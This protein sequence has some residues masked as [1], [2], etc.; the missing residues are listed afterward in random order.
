GAWQITGEAIKFDTNGALADGQHRLSAVVES[1]ASVDMLVVRG[2]APEAQTVMDSGAKRTASDA[3]TLVGQKHPAV[4]A[5]AA[6]FALREPGA[7]YVA[8]DDAVRNPTNT[9]IADFIA[10]NP[11]LHQAAEIA[12]HYYPSFDAPPSVLAV[13][14]MRF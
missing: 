3:L 2:V 1:G 11:E 6:R 7:G 13:C 10:Q 14:W 4:L 5:A 12:Q 8:A 9:E